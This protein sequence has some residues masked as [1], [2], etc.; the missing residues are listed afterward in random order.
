MR[1]VE[2]KVWEIEEHPNKEKCYTYI[3]E[4]MHTLNNH[5][6][7]E[8]IETLKAL[9]REIGGELDYI[10]SATPDRGEYIT[11]TGYDKGALKEL[12]ADDLPLTGVFWDYE[13]IHGLHKFNSFKMLLEALHRHT[14]YVYSDEGLYEL[15]IANGWEFDEQGELI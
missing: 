15:A 2:T 13:A 1:T 4:N 3:R 14:D 12:N 6:L 8:V 7:D 9:Q 10:I 5:S 11:L